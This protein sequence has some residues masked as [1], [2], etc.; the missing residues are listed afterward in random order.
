MHYL[1]MSQCVAK[2]YG[3]N[4][5]MRPLLSQVLPRIME[6]MHN[7]IILL[8]YY[9]NIIIELWRNCNIIISIELLLYYTIEFLLQYI[10]SLNYGGIACV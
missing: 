6:E 3:I 2:M 10:L 9:Y 5:L 1:Y 7:I 8:N 4:T